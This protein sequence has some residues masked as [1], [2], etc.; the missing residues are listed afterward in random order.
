MVGFGV[1]DGGALR[2]IPG[3]R[4][5]G[6]FGSLR[7]LRPFLPWTESPPDVP[8][9]KALRQTM[10]LAQLHPHRDP[11][12]RAV[13]NW[14][15][16]Q[17]RKANRP[18]RSD[19]STAASNR[20]PRGTRLVTIASPQN[21]QL[22]YVVQSKA[23]V[24]RAKAEESRLLQDYQQWLKRQNRSLSS[25]RYGRLRCDAYERARH[26]LIEAKSSAKR[27]HIRMAVGQLLD[28]AFQGRKKLP[29]PA[30][31]ILVPHKPERK[32]VQWLQSLKISII[33]REG[34]KFFDN[35]NS[36]FV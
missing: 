33:W 20:R 16:R 6:K 25:V 15:E 2:R 24:I 7:K 19:N 30:M 21:S 28:Y 10:A 9:I 8:V 34:D 36:R 12:H 3:F 11:D 32:D 26:N 4:A 22:D 35:A 17:I 31:A 5:P 14:M 18:T 23:K 13:C 27:G 1:V 29:D